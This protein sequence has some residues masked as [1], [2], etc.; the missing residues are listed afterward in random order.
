LTPRAKD[1]SSVAA[2]YI[3]QVVVDTPWQVEI[4]GDATWVTTDVAEGT[5]NG[6][7]TIT[8]EENATGRDREAEVRIAGL[9]HKVEQEGR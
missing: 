2:S 4:P 8:V 1:V 3:V 9:V 7:V 5:G 6:Q